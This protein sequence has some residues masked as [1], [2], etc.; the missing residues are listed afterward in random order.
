MA[1]RGN[2]YGALKQRRLA[3]FLQLMPD[4]LE[5]QAGPYFKS[6]SADKG[7]AFMEYSGADINC[8]SMQFGSRFVLR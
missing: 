5:L 4:Q 3:V 6:L 1:A 8:G 2:I 7:K